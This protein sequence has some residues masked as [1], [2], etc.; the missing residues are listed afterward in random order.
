MSS[1]RR[2]VG[3]PRFIGGGGTVSSPR[4]GG[5][6]VRTENPRVITEEVVQNT[7]GEE[8]VQNDIP[9]VEE[10]TT[11]PLPRERTVT[12]YETVSRSRRGRDRTSTRTGR[13]TGRGITFSSK[14]LA[15][16][17]NI[18]TD[19]QEYM[20]VST[21]SNIEVECKFGLD[22]STGFTTRVSTTILPVEQ[23]ELSLEVTRDYIWNQSTSRSIRHTGDRTYRKETLLFRDYTTGTFTAKVT[24]ATE[25]DVRDVTG[26]QVISNATLIRDK[27]RYSTEYRGTILSLTYVKT[28]RTK[29]TGGNP[30]STE[31]EVEAL[32]GTTMEQF[33]SVVQEMT[34][35]L[36]EWY[37]AMTVYQSAM[38]PQ[39]NRP[40]IYTPFR[41]TMPIAF[42]P[43]YDLQGYSV[44]HKMD[45]DR[46]NAIVVNGK[47]YFMT[48]SYGLQFT[49]VTVTD[50]TGR[51]VVDGEWID[52]F[53][54]ED[55]DSLSLLED[56]HLIVFD[57][58]YDSAIGTMLENRYSDRYDR[59]EQWVN[60]MEVQNTELVLSPLMIPQDVD[61]VEDTQSDGSI[62]TVWIH[63]N[64]VLY[65]TDGL[66]LQ[67]YD[68]T[69]VTGTDTKQYKWKEGANTTVDFRPRLSTDK[70]DLYVNTPLG[71]VAATSTTLDSIPTDYEIR[72]QI[73]DGTVCEFAYDKQTSRWIFHRLR[74]DK[75][76]PNF[77]TVA[78]DNMESAISA[79]STDEMLNLLQSV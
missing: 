7:E 49:N 62:R 19:F 42:R 58:M 50:T 77:I 64:E 28:T 72:R 38:D 15:P 73:E 22:R 75:S 24:A 70:I 65:Y 12:R 63:N 53:L 69:Y 21:D 4:Y 23:S 78:F 66:I 29:T 31:I 39:S 35:R 1:N 76:V 18:S 3:I 55:D 14:E 40:A 57:M 79:V 5:S 54:I 47:V 51:Y 33:M 20:P 68:S 25:I 67:S 71:E 11:A 10:Q 9:P 56:K 13:G 6:E 32:P 41:G 45:G 27:T 8:T 74:A 36:N 48:R 44:K 2:R 43:S 61:I 37:S 30:N 16:I 60:R 46:V 52:A 17:S 26:E 59:L 34:D